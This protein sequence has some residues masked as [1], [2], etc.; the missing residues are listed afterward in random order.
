MMD[1]EPDIGVDDVIIPAAEL[2]RR[3]SRLPDHAAEARAL[4]SLAEAMATSPETVLQRLVE[5]VLELTTSDSAGVSILEEQDRA[6]I[7]RWRAIAGAFAANLNGTMPPV[8]SPCGTVMARDQV[9]LFT[10]AERFFPELRAAKPSAYES[11]LVPFEVGGRPAGTVWAIKHR[12]ESRFEPEDAR[13]L[14][15]IA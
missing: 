5:A 3:P 11:L 10:E 12:P 8:A 15:R 7:L 13:L 6:P 9:L 1:P 2:A 4:A 14:P